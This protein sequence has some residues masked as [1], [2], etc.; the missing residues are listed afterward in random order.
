M[1][2]R[3]SYIGFEI[4]AGFRDRLLGLLAAR[5]RVGRALWLE[6]CAM[7]HTFGMRAAIDLVFVGQRGQVL[8]VDPDVAPWR[9]HW[10]AGARAVIEMPAGAS[11]RYRVRAGMSVSTVLAF[12]HAADSDES[13]AGID[14][15]A[16]H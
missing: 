8:R 16:G 14:E 9:V 2:L 7:V 13:A 12:E 4:A 15:R 6:P 5:R 3:S 11:E 1:T 10:C